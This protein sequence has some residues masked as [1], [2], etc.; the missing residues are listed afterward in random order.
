MVA[1][2]YGFFWGFLLIG[3]A[4]TEIVFVL[5]TDYFVSENQFISSVTV[6]L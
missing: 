2:I 3:S 5:I 6:G 4:I 1:R